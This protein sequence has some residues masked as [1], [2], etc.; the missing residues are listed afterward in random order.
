MKRPS[1]GVTTP[2]STDSAKRPEIGSVQLGGVPRVVLRISRD[3]PL[4]AE[5]EQAGVDIL[6]LRVDQLRQHTEG[7]VVTEV[8]RLKRRGLPIIGTVRSPDE[9]GAG[10]LD[11]ARR[12]V[13]YDAIIPLVD[14]VDVELNSASVLRATLDVAR[15]N[16]RTII[17]SFH[18]FSRTPSSS[19]LEAIVARATEAGANI[20][21]IATQA[22]DQA[23]VTR[24]FRFTEEHRSRNLVTIAMGAIGS[25]SRLIFPLAGS[26]MT[27]T[28]LSPTDGQIP[29]DRLVDHLRFYYPAYNEELVGRLQLLQYA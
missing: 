5:A 7:A 23:D 3:D 11:I 15:Q 12:A 13:L 18:D 25:I 24:L 26:L 6:E 28:S 8:K 27:Y 19:E 29:L 10:N 22:T 16:R 4:L 9:G 21:K 20:I 2:K 14:A 1:P 17:L